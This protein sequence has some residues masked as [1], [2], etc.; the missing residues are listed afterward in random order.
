[1][2][3]YHQRG[4]I[5]LFPATKQRVSCVTKQLA[6]MHL[7]VGGNDLE[8]AEDLQLF[9]DDC[10]TLFNVMAHTGFP[11][12]LSTSGL[13]SY[14]LADVSG[15]PLHV[16]LASLQADVGCCS[17]SGGC[18]EVAAQSSNRGCFKEQPR[19][20]SG[21]AGI[22]A[23]HEQRNHSHRHSMLFLAKARE[24]WTLALTNAAA[25]HDP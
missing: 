18:S 10:K 12:P 11:L 21:G 5:G 16:L 6:P 17:D 1:M 3:Y 7:Q 2:E 20:K 15:A 19:D 24:L 14:H 25:K 13:Q 23:A 22:F 8:V 9:P 4:D